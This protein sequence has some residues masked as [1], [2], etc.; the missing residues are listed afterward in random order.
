MIDSG[1]DMN[2]ALPLLSTY[3]GH[4]TLSSTEHYLRLTLNMYPYLE[5][6][7]SVTLK[8]IFGGTKPW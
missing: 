5:K 6:K 3:L 2:V 1:L 8:E 4:R 7:F